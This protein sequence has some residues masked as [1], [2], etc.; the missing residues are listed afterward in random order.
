MDRKDVEHI[1]TQYL[2]LFGISDTVTK[3]A[4]KPPTSHGRTRFAWFVGNRYFGTSRLILIKRL[5]VRFTNH[6]ASFDCGWQIIPTDSWLAGRPP[7]HGDSPLT[8]P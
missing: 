7:C 6:R 2:E 1:P 4:A 3:E 5:A 8:E